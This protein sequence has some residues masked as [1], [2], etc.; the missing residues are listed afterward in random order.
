MQRLGM[1]AGY[2]RAEIEIGMGG[3]R[4]MGLRD[5][6]QKHT[7]THRDTHTHACTCGLSTDLVETKVE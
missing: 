5:L 4:E 7:H 6:S 1:E 2:Q 3:R